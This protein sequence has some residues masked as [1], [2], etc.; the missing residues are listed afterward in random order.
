MCVSEQA[1]WLMESVVR[2]FA[3]DG[4]HGVKLLRYIPSDRM[5]ASV[6]MVLLLILNACVCFDENETK[7]RF[8]VVCLNSTQLMLY[9]S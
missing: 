8:T 2:R 6:K 4:E 9:K 7:K 1:L 5:E 3:K